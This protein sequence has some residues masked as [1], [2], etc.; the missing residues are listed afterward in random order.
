MVAFRCTEN[1]TSSAFARATWA[2]R[3][4]RS[5]ATCMTDAST[6]S[7]ASTGIDSRSTVVVPSAPANSIRSEP[8][9][10]ITADFSVERK[11]S[12]PIVATLVF[13]SAVQAPIRCGWVLA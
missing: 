13:E 5:A 4:S 2:V 12:S 6:T 3:N 10:S 1:S 8:S 9:A 11:S 7:P